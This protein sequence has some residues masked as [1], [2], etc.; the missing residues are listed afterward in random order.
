[1]GSTFNPPTIQD[2]ADLW[3]SQRGVNLGIKGDPDHVAGGVSYHLGKDD[4]RPDARSIQL[5]RDRQGLTNAA[6]A[7]D[8]GKLDNSFSSLRVFSIWLVE[9]CRANKTARADV[10]EIIHTADGTKV[11]R[12]SGVD[13]KVH[14]GPATATTRT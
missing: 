6:S 9:R 2:L 4:L 13:N 8:L 3:T 5:A 11:Q 14:K 12:Y 10:R 7:L 1:M